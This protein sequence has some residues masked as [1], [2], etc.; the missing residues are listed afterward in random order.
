MKQASS[1]EKVNKETASKFEKVWT[2]GDKV[3]DVTISS[4]MWKKWSEDEG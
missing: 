4:A 2:K 3:N 1:R